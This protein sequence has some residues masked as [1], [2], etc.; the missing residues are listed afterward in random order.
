M[1]ARRTLPPL[2][3]L[4]NF[5]CAARLASFARA[6]DELGVTPAAVSKQVKQLEARLGVELFF[7]TANGLDLTASGLEYLKGL[8]TAFELIEGATRKIEERSGEALVR[9][10]VLPNFAMHWL[11]PHLPAYL[12]A[13]PD[14]SVRMTSLDPNSVDWSTSDLS[15]TFGPP[16]G[17]LRSR[18]LFRSAIAIVASPSLA[19]QV[20]QHKDLLVH[21]LLRVAGAPHDWETW[22]SAHGLHSPNTQSHWF[23]SYALALTAAEAGL[24][25]ATGRHPLLSRLLLGRRVQVLFEPVLDRAS[26]WH[27]SYPG[28]RALPPSVRT[29]LDWITKCATEARGSA[30]QETG[31]RL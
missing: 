17:A 25:I 19:V 29:F 22:L 12:A 30:F 28:G 13:N 16:P 23:D 10:N 9:I 8:G 11:I 7:R 6:A 18:R 4:R 27:I 24:G 3:A 26:G 5:E 31:L 2:T 20:N 1:V 14:V 21:R 15:I